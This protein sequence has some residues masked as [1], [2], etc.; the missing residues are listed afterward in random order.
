MLMPFGSSSKRSNHAGRTDEFISRKRE[1][2]K[3]TEIVTEEFQFL[4]NI[5]RES[6]AADARIIPAGRI[7]VEDR[8]RQKCRMGCYEYGK[9]LS[10]PPHAP[11]VEEFRRSL[12]EYHYALIVMFHSETEFKEEN[13]YSL[14]RDLI[15]QSVPQTT[16]NQRSCF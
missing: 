4:V 8:V 6:G 9:Y 3:K 1:I 13:R 5:A 11:P 16:R 7:I 12:V 10:C 2:M 15:D 14:F